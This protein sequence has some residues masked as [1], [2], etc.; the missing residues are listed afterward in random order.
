VIYTTPL[1][2]GIL[3]WI[4]SSPAQEKASAGGLYWKNT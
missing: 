3:L 1:S 2:L 4:F